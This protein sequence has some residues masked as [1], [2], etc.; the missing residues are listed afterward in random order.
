MTRSSP[1]RLGSVPAGVAPALLV[2]AVLAPAVAEAGCS[3]LVTSRADSERL[4]SLI[5]PLIHEP[6]DRSGERP[7]SPS[8][9]P[10]SGAFCSGQPATPAVPAMAYDGQ[11]DSWAWDAS[12]PALAPIAAT[13]L[14]AESSDLHP[15]HRAIAIFHPPPC[16]PSAR[17]PDRR[18]R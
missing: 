9:R 1:K 7:A 14:P 5:D 18:A 2:L 17:I 12:V 6:S 8:P 3:H 11:F 15:M 4:S 13:F 16:L 10:C